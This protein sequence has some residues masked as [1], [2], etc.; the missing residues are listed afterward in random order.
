[1]ILNMDEIFCFFAKKYTLYSM[2]LEPFSIFLQL[3]DC[4]A[5]IRDSIGG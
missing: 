3:A 1:M 4:N 2:Q 5:A